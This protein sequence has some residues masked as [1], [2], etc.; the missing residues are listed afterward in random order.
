MNDEGVVWHWA[1]L[2]CRFMPRKANLTNLFAR[3]WRIGSMEQWDQD[4]VEEEEEGYFEFNDNG[5][6]EFHFGYVHRQ[7]GCRLTTRGG[8]QAIE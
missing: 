6:G 2:N 5:H 3:R 8:M 1:G 7:M 4:F